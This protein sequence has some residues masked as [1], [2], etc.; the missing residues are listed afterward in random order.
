MVSAED[1]NALSSSL[2]HWE[3]AGYVAVA[4]VAIGV[5]GEVIHDF[6]DWFKS[7]DWW[8]TKGNKASALL[9]I[10]ALVAELVI[11]V[12]TN[13]ISGRVIALLEE[14]A[15][16]T[17]ERA[18][19]IEEATAWRVLDSGK[20]QKFENAISS[21]A[22]RQLTI[23]FAVGDP[24]SISLAIQ[25]VNL[26]LTAHWNVQTVGH[27]YEGSLVPGI[28]VLGSDQ[29]GSALIKNAL[30]AA[31]LPYSSEPV[32]IPPMYHGG[33]PDERRLFLYLGTK[34]APNF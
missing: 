33:T 27:W 2:S 3:F 14:Q 32:P 31:N 16:E 5:A 17:R 6:L 28:R 10:A 29:A 8:R 4:A 19:H 34:P 20:T 21:G 24:E 13:S 1:L 15:A 11:Q 23:G 26:F 18:A 25:I 22:E 9:L 7:L 12:R 30:T